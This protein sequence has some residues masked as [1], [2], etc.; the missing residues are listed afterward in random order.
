MKRVIDTGIAI[1]L[2]AVAGAAVMYLLD[3]EAGR[4]RRQRLADATEAAVGSTGHSLHSAL[5]QVASH[6]SDARQR[7]GSNAQSLI[8][9]ALD[10]AEGLRSEAQGKID[11]GRRWLQPE[12]TTSSKAIHATALGLGGTG[13]VAVGVAAMYLLDAQHGQER[14]E[15]LMNKANAL[16]ADIGA[17]SRRVGRLVSEKLGRTSSDTSS[18]SMPTSPGA[19]VPF[20]NSTVD[21]SASASVDPATSPERLTPTGF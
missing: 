11:D 21:Y 2:S 7:L 16:C 6:T 1:G 9:R 20:E 18:Y 3:P 4:K 8:D 5:Q 14:R 10:A 17:F 15:S 19:D 13:A 12:P